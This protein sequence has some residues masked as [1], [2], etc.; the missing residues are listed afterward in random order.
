L[1][2]AYLGK[3]EQ[4]FNEFVRHWIR[5]LSV[6]KFEDA[7]NQID[8]PN[9]YGIEWTEASIRKVID[10]YIGEGES[11]SITD[12]AEMQGDGRPNLI[13]FKGLT[14]FAFDLNLPINE[15]WSDL[16]IQF[17]FIRKRKGYYSVILQNI[18]VL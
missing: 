11:Y 18:H 7:V 14:G 6:G 4:I 12:P 8:G 15:E 17:E 16:T 3:H 10:E 5:L 13:I 9:S 2:R 1:I